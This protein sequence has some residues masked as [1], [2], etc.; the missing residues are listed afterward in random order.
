M[1]RRANLAEGEHERTR[2]EFW[3]SSSQKLL[4]RRSSQS[5]RVRKLTIETGRT[6]IWS[7]PWPVWYKSK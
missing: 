4:A 3:M 1:G 5:V 2:D 7:R 6:E